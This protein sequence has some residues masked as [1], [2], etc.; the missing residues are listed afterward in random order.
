VPIGIERMMRDSRING[1]FEGSSEIM[2]L[3]MAREAVDK[4]LAIAGDLLDPSKTKAQKLRALA[5][6]IGFYAWWYP[7]RWLGWRSWPRFRRFGALAEHLRFVEAAGRKLARS[8]FHGM[9]VYGAARLERRQAFLF[10]IVDIAMEL[11]A[12]TAVIARAQGLHQAGSVGAGDAAELADVFCR[13]SREVVASRFRALWRNDDAKK[14]VLAQHVL[15]GRDTW[16][17][18]GIVGLRRTANEIGPRPPTVPQTTAPSPA[19]AAASP[20]AGPR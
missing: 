16:L 5:R 14:D 17:E 15:E 2:H 10:R 12:M 18:E 11:F 13:G 1:I 9:V 7:T 4:H 19:A 20:M 6:A 3:F 8:I